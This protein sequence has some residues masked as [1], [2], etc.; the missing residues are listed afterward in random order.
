MLVTTI[1]V[2]RMLITMS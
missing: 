1:A 2:L